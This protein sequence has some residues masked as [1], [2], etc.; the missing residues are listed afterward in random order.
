MFFVY[1]RMIYIYHMR[2]TSSL[3]FYISSFLCFIYVLF[4]S[5][6]YSAKGNLQLPKAI[7]TIYPSYVVYF[8]RNLI[9]NYNR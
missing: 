6:Y 7:H 2:I 4:L 9:G 5:Y 1:C 8:D 3:T